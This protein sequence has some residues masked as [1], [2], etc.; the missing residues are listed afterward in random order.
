MAQFSSK[1][2]FACIS[3]KITSEPKYQ[4]V[5]KN[6][7]P[8]CTAGVLVDRRGEGQSAQSV[9]ADVKAWNDLAL[10]LKDCR[11]GDF[12]FATGKVRTESWT[13]RDTGMERSKKVF[14]PDFLAATRAAAPV[15]QPE[16]PLRELE[17]DDGELPF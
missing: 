7:T 17:D 12:L 15:V 5:G 14:V 6:S 4:E 3:G 8:M 10:L 11:K 13:D 16:D 9:F 1:A 2:G